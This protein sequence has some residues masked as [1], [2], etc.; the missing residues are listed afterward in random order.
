MEDD[1]SPDQEICASR[2]WEQ[3]TLGPMWPVE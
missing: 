1:L 2:K 3:V